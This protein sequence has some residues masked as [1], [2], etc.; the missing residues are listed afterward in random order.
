[1]LQG[2]VLKPPHWSRAGPWLAAVTQVAAAVTQVAAAAPT[3]HHGG[4]CQMSGG[5]KVSRAQRF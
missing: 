3:T 5:P 1:M 2:S 4:S